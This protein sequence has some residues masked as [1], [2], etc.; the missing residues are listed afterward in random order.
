MAY[1]TTTHGS[2]KGYTAAD[3][4]FFKSDGSLISKETAFD[5]AKSIKAIGGIG[6]YDFNSIHIDLRDRVNGN[7]TTWDWRSKK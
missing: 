6:I 2:V 4:S 3:V 5:K 7:P 1:S